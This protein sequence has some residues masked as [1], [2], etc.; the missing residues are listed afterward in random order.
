M[1]F[2]PVKMADRRAEMFGEPIAVTTKDL[3][4]RD[5]AGTQIAWGR[6]V[7]QAWPCNEC[8][9]LAFSQDAHFGWHLKIDNIDQRVVAQASH[10]HHLSAHGGPR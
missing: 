3:E 8:G 7:M 4:L 6:E 5:P 2:D 1:S 10:G 9:S